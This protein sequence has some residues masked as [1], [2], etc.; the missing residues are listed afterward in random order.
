MATRMTGGYAGIALK[1]ILEGDGK[2]QSKP[3]LVIIYES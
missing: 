2:G 3:S 1:I